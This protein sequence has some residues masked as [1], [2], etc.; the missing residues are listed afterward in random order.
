[1]NHGLVLALSSQTLQSSTV[2]L[3]AGGTS[4]RSDPSMVIRGEL[5]GKLSQLAFIDLCPFLLVYIGG[6][7]CPTV[8]M[9]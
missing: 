7:Q 6:K 2:W 3:S 4:Q 5:M 1:M 9:S 8:L